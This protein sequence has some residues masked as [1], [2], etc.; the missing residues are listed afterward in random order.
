MKL[1]N[2]FIYL[3]CVED[4]IMNTE[5]KAKAVSSI[6]DLVDYIN[7]KDI[8]KEDIVSIMQLGING[9]VVIYYTSIKE[10]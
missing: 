8:N 5:A 4:N 7:K 6:R 9:Y 3:D 1:I 10:G 2:I